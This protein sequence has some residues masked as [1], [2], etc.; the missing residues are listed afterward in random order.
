MD[1]WNNLFSRTKTLDT[2]LHRNQK[3]NARVI[4]LLAG[5]VEMGHFV[6]LMFSLCNRKRA[7]LSKEQKYCITSPKDKGK[8]NLIYLNSHR[9]FAV[10]C[11]YC[12]NT[13]KQKYTTLLPCLLWSPSQ[14]L[15]GLFSQCPLF[16]VNMP[17]AKFP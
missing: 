7:W 9:Y 2:D 3:D 6:Y 11:L 15:F 16:P 12:Q 14:P 1:C 4:F 8:K 17:P 10:G 13:S 5:W